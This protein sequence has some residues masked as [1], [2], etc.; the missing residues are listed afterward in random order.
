MIRQLCFAFALSAMLLSPAVDAAKRKLPDALDT[1]EGALLKHL[2]DEP[3]AAKK[4]ALMED[5]VAKHPAHE[6]ALWVIG[7]LQ[8]VYLKAAQFDKALAAGEKVVAADPDDV[9]MANGNLKAAEGLKDV[10]QIRKW[11][12]AA[13]AAAR[14]AMAGPQPDGDE[15]AAWLANAAYAK[16]VDAYCDYA[17]YSLAAQ[18]SNPAEKIEVSDLL[19]KQSPASQYI[20]ALRPQLFVAYQQTGNHTRALAL[21]EE[22][23]KAKRASDDMVL[24]AATKAYARQDKAQTTA[25]AKLLVDTLPAKAAPEGVSDADWT[26]SKNLKLGVSH[27]MLGVLASNEQRWADAD[28]HLRAA[29]PLISHSRDTQ[30]ETLFHLGLANYKLG[31]AKANKS[32]ILDAL[33]FNS[34][35]AAIPGPFQ[36]QA[37]KNVAAIRS[38]YHIQ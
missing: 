22:E 3:D 8:T 33:K 11:A 23:I 29:L 28:I 18:A 38:Q 1:P 16:Q 2:M 34:Q 4:T 17:L 36:A 25:Y 5:F 27:W 37:K 10:A 21:A 20:A 14:R 13:S 15:A 19:L 26:R 7:E 6:G 12:I 24:Y 30:A 31:D 35:C 9:V 32:R